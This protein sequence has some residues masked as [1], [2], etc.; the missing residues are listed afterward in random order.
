VTAVLADPAWEDRVRRALGHR[1]PTELT[2]FVTP[3]PGVVGEVQR[4]AATGARALVF[5]RDASLAEAALV[6]AAGADGY[7]TE[8]AMLNFA[9]RRVADGE[10]WFDPVAAA[11]VARLARLSGNARH[12]PLT[13][14]ARLAAAGR[15]WHEA[16]AAAGAVD[17]GVLLAR[18]R[19]RL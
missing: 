11:A 12:D 16:Q 14:A 19:D 6:I 8:L 15:P 1:S 13:V 4:T 18:L 17:A 5:A 10:G 7:V 9:S 2:V 3:R